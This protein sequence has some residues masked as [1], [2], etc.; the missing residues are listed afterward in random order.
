MK[1]IVRLK[2]SELSKVIKKIIMEQKG[3]NHLLHPLYVEFDR[4]ING[5]NVELKKI[6]NNQI[7][8]ICDWG[9]EPK[10]YTLVK[11]PIK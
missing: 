11:T 4:D 10:I 7:K 6:N 5:D 9:E 1:K 3:D 8:F 2:E